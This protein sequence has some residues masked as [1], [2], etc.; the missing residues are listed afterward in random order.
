MFEI[1][2]SE[3][4]IEFL[5]REREIDMGEIKSMFSTTKHNDHKHNYLR[6]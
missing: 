5:K 3:K 6:P 4:D 1:E 2:L